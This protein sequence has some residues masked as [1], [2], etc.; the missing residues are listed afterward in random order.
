MRVHF[1]EGA[2]TIEGILYYVERESSFAFV[3][4]VVPE[5]RA[6]GVAPLVVAC[7]LGIEASVVSRRLLDVA[8]F[9]P[10][11][12]WRPARLT[13]PL[14]RSVALALDPGSTLRDRQAIKVAP[15]GWPVAFDDANDWLRFAGD[16]GR[17]EEAAEIATGVIV[18]TVEGTLHSV[19]LKPSFVEN[20]PR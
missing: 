6:G 8:G 10:R 4:R 9:C 2:G 13:P 18:G 7:G 14:A 3:P 5:A 19:W 12:T 20:Y 1:V 17:D 15:D 11:E 16:P